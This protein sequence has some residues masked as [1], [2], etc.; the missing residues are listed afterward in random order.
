MSKSK[1][2]LAAL[3]AGLA[4]ALALNFALVSAPKNT[5]LSKALA[6]EARQ[7]AAITAVV[8]GCVAKAL[9]SGNEGLIF[10]I[11]LSRGQACMQI[12]GDTAQKAAD[13]KG[14]CDADDRKCLFTLGYAQTARRALGQEVKT[15]AELDALQTEIDQAFEKI[16][17]TQQ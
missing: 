5:D 10:A 3:A 8:Q 15:D 2:L 17:S 14:L 1:K 7:E 11:N 4:I 12:T 16:T 6:A 13:G 9:K